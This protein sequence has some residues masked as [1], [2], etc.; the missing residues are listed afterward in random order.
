M[1]C[2]SLHMTVSV[3]AAD[4][5]VRRKSNKKRPDGTMTRPL[6]QE[7]H[8]L[9]LHREMFSPI[10]TDHTSSDCLTARENLFSVIAHTSA[11]NRILDISYLIPSRINYLP[12]CFY[13]F[14]FILHRRCLLRG[15]RSISTG[16]RRSVFVL[17]DDEPA[18]RRKDKEALGTVCHVLGR[19][20]SSAFYGVPPAKRRSPTQ[21]CRHP[22]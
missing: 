20:S 13:V 18:L 19:P 22:R 11:Y 16:K 7:T 14:I 9:P 12:R 5:N 17:R 21:T 2:R 15:H 6:L 8:G 3:L 10:I 1:S 4:P